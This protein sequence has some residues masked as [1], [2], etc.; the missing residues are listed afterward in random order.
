MPL[1]EYEHLRQKSEEYQDTLRE[2]KEKSMTEEA[3]AEAE[4]EKKQADQRLLP[5]RSLPREARRPALLRRA[6]EASRAD[7]ARLCGEA[8]VAE[9]DDKFLAGPTPQESIVEDRREYSRKIL[10]RLEG[11]LAA[12]REWVAADNLPPGMTATRAKVDAAI[13][14]VEEQAKGCRSLID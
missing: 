7:A 8:R 3:E 11:D 12:M 2:K 4:K 1:L 5:L 14:C 13:A 10:A 9:S 6:A